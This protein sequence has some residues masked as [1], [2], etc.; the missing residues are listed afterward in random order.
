MIKNIFFFACVLAGMACTS[1]SKDEFTVKGKLDKPF[2]GTVYLGHIT[3][4]FTNIDSVQLTNA[5]EFSFT[6]HISNPDKYRISFKPYCN[7]YEFIAEAEGCYELKNDSVTVIQGKEQELMNRYLKTITPIRQEAEKLMNLYAEAETAKDEKALSELRE[8]LTQHFTKEQQTTVDFI[9]SCPSSYTAVDLAG[10]LLL[11]EYPEWKEVYETVDTI[12]YTYS[13]AF[14]SLQ[15]KMNEA[16]SLWIQD[17]EAPDFTTTDINGKTVKLSDF[18]G[19]YLLL[20]FWASW[21][22][23]CR[24]KA[25][26]IKKIYPQLKAKGIQIC[27]INLDDE[28][29]KW[30]DASQEDGILWINTSEQ[31]SFRD[32]QIAKDYKVTQ[33]P[34]LFVID[35]SGKIVKQNPDIDHLLNLTTK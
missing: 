9:K 5:T 20:D 3:D 22:R 2:T 4:K 14:R 31:K 23:P 7:G 29:K 16:R 12:N 24:D 18:K 8:K 32:N 10:N 27:G 35:P 1:Q 25:K 30:L 28:R 21:C 6:Q 15:E 33:I 26:E 11:R 13:Y 19:N 17:I 34:A